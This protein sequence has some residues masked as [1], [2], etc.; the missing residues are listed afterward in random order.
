MSGTDGFETRNRLSRYDLGS[1]FIA[2]S[3]PEHRCFSLLQLGFVCVLWKFLR[4]M[5]VGTILDRERVGYIYLYL[6]IYSMVEDGSGGAMLTK[7]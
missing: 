5:P 3:S 2:Q 1:F 7:R 4:Q 6:Y